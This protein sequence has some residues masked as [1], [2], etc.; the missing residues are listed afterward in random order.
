MPEPGYADVD[1]LDIEA[2]ELRSWKSTVWM[3]LR[4]T[5]AIGVPYWTMI[6][7]VTEM[8]PPFTVIAIGWRCQ[9]PGNLAG[10]R[11]EVVDPMP[12]TP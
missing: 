1:A 7:I 3:T 6:G 9:G 12:T 5:V 8:R 2:S 4:A 10:N 11:R